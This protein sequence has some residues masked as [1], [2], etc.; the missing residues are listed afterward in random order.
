MRRVIESTLMSTDGVIGE[1]HLWTDN[2]FGE[3]TVA[4][5]R[6]RLRHADAMLTSGFG[7]RY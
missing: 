4:Y 6:E 5:A 1:P 2:R 3:M 7:L